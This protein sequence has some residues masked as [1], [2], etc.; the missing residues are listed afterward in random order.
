MYK[1]QVCQPQYYK[2][3]YCIGSECKNNC[4]HSWVITIDEQTYNKYM[5]LGEDLANE[6]R[7][8]ITV[9]S[10][11]PFLAAINMDKDKKCHSLTTRDYVI[12]RQDLDMNT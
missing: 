12:Y 5:N 9:A 2:Q 10:K 8:K 11:E 6:Y 3:F 7:K 4:C 1:Y